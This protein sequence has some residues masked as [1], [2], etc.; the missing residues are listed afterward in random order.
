MS[1]AL[2]SKN[3]SWKKESVGSW[4]RK[5]YMLEEKH[6]TKFY[7]QHF[8]CVKNLVR[9]L[10]FLETIPSSSSWS[11]SDGLFYARQFLLTFS[12][13]HKCFVQTWIV[14][15]LEPNKNFTVSFS[16]EFFTSFLLLSFK[17]KTKN[18]SI[19]V[20]KKPTKFLCKFL[21]SIKVFCE[22]SFILKCYC[23]LLIKSRMDLV[24]F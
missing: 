22:F 8:K 7:H 21:L 1:C 5:C 13:P 9:S 17:N 11:I 4:K 14:N 18:K 20:K 2:I 16:I 24:T 3:L 15:F 6:F 23:L 10:S 12:L 19:Y